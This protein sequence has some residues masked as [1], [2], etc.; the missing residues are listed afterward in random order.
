MVVTYTHT[1]NRAAVGYQHTGK[2]FNHYDTSRG[3]VH[4]LN[5]G[6]YREYMA[7]CGVT[8]RED[9]SDCH[10]QDGVNPIELATQGVRVTCKGCLKRKPVA[11][12]LPKKAKYVVFLAV[13]TGEVVRW[14]TEWSLD[15]A[16]RYAE[17]I[18]EGGRASITQPEGYVLNAW[19]E[20]RMEA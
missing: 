12:L 5:K 11:V 2:D 8:V 14:C 18:A 17:S 15:R 3:K 13:C 16:E 4:A 1:G 6:G 7:V 19:A 9:S 20:V 10:D